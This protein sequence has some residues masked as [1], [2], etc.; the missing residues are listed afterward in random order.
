MKTINKPRLLRKAAHILLV[1]VLAIGVSSCGEDEPNLPDDP[2][3]PK[4]DINDDPFAKLPELDPLKI[5]GLWYLSNSNKTTE[6]FI[7]I[8]EYGDMT[9]YM[10]RNGQYSFYSFGNIIELSSPGIYASFNL[11]NKEGYDV[12][13]I[14]LND[15]VLSITSSN[16]NASPDDKYPGYWNPE[17]ARNI[18]NDLG[19]ELKW[20]SFSLDYKRADE[21]TLKKRLTVYPSYESTVFSNAMKNEWCGICGNEIINVDFRD[22][23]YFDSLWGPVS[24]RG[25]YRLLGCNIYLAGDTNI[26]NTWCDKAKPYTHFNVSIVD[27]S[28]KLYLVS[29]DGNTI[30]TFDKVL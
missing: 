27:N 20:D 28:S 29:D 15:G 4:P 9:F 14:E 11:F 7:R 22:N 5:A 19:S 10:F 21:S 23:Y 30:F 26:R 1:L 13:R 25:E 12:H 18:L 16:T 8:G 17:I 3:I 24:E 6:H 2:E